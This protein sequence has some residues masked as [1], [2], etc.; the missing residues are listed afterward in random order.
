MHIYTYYYC[1]CRYYYHHNFDYKF[2]NRLTF[3]PS[4][5]TPSA[6][7]KTDIA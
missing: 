5:A 7:M 1:C 2:I 3:P 4:T 6:T